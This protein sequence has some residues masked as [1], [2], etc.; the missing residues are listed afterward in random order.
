M[1]HLRPLLHQLHA[2]L[3][4]RHR[5][6]AVQMVCSVGVRFILVWAERLYIQ[7]LL[8][9]AIDTLL[10]NARSRGYKRVCER[11]RSSQVSY[12]WLDLK[13]TGLVLSTQPWASWWFAPWLLRDLLVLWSTCLYACVRICVLADL[14]PFYRLR[15]G[16]TTSSFSRKELMC[17]GKMRRSTLVKL[18]FPYVSRSSGLSWLRSLWRAVWAARSSDTIIATFM[19]WRPLAYIAW[20][21]TQLV[22]LRVL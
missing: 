8:A 3:C 13:T 14:L 21:S 18:C 15:W 22:V 11:E 2:V 7:S 20:V 16:S 4:G 5:H 1:W 9:R 19:P 17:R 12:V 6:A 10:L